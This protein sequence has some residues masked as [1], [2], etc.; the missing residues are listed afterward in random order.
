MQTTLCICIDWNMSHQG[1]HLAFSVSSALGGGTRTSVCLHMDG[2]PQC[3]LVA[4]KYAAELL[5]VKHPISERRSIFA[6]LKA[7]HI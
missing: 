2:V 3:E 7:C 1:A 6:S 4:P 5:V